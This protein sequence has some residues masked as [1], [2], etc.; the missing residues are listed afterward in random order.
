M[1]WASPPGVH[2]AIADRIIDRT[3][4][5]KSARRLIAQNPSNHTVSCAASIIPSVGR[6]NGLSAAIAS[7]LAELVTSEV[8]AVY[9]RYG[10]ADL[11]HHA[12]G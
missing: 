6:A 12:D 4:F 10:S 7:F 2:P 3:A 9:F 5:L 1:I 11:I 8:T